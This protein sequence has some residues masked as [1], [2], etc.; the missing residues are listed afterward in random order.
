MHQESFVDK[1]N[2]LVSRKYTSRRLGGPGTL[3][4]PFN[5]LSSQLNFSFFAV[6]MVF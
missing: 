2:I 6:Q 1:Q 4:G 5:E 3:T